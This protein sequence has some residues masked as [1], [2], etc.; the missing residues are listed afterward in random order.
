MERYKGQLMQVTMSENLLEW[1]SIETAKSCRN[2]E[3]KRQ[4][5]IADT[6]SYTPKF[7]WTFLRTE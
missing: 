6:D 2:R 3:N 1:K 7:R 5:M 4:T